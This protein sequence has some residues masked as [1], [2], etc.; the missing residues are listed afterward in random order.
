MKR[1]RVEPDQD[2]RK[3]ASPSRPDHRPGSRGH[4]L[5]G[6]TVTYIGWQLVAH[7]AVFFKDLLF[8]LFEGIAFAIHTDKTDRSRRTLSSDIS[9]LRA[10]DD[11]AGMRISDHKGEVVAPGESKPFDASLQFLIIYHDYSEYS[12]STGFQA[13]SSTKGQLAISAQAQARFGRDASC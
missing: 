13:S 9:G 8:S 10:V 4:G 3:R 12:G 5:R 2:E 6:V 11:T 1:S 7:L